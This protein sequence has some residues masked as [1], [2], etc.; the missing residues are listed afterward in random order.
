MTRKKA[1]NPG[2]VPGNFDFWK[3][4]GINFSSGEVLEVLSA[5]CFNFIEILK[6]K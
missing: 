4:F 2:K 5:V 6:L 1:G 3:S